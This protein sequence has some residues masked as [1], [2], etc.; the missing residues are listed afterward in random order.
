MG[1]TEG[2]SL[3]ELENER[4]ELLLNRAKEAL[5]EL[6]EQY[7]ATI[8]L[9]LSVDNDLYGAVLGKGVTIAENLAQMMID[10]K[11]IHKFITLSLHTYVACKDK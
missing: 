4:I 5:D 7:G 10:D 8:L 6:H 1:Q 9:S 2:K 11:A 3:K